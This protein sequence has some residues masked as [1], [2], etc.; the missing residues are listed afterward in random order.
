MWRKSV[1]FLSYKGLK[2]SVNTFE[3]D[4]TPWC[5]LR[6]SKLLLNRKL[7]IRKTKEMW[8]EA[9]QQPLWMFELTQLAYKHLFS[10]AYNGSEGHFNPVPAGYMKLSFSFDSW[11]MVKK[12]CPNLAGKVLG[13]FGCPYSKVPHEKSCWWSDVL[14]AQKALLPHNLYSWWLSLQP[15][16]M[17][18]G[19]QAAG[20]GALGCS[21]AEASETSTKGLNTLAVLKEQHF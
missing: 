8:D 4:S 16:V 6:P 5:C 1:C 21:G 9:T 3:V 17:E 18:D 2:S 12:H 11:R 7:K 13:Y 19:K 14:R 20:W 10:T 15:S